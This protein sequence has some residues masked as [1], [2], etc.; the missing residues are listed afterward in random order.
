MVSVGMAQEEI[1]DLVSHP[2]GHSPWIA[3][4]EQQVA[5]LV[6]ELQL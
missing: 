6:Q 3:Q 2:R 4:V 1:A 5:P